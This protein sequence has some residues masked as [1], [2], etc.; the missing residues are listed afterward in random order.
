[1][2]YTNLLVQNLVVV[3]S[4]KCSVKIR[5]FRNGLFEGLECLWQDKKCSIA[6]YVNLR[7]VL[8][9]CPNSKDI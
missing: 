4:V 2:L 5:T 9:N 3:L 1:V 6:V 8:V 7:F